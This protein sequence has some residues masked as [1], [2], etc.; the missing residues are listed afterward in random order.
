MKQMERNDNW[1]QNKKNWADTALRARE[2]Y[3]IATK[4]GKPVIVM[5]PIKGGT[6]ANVPEEAE[7]ILKAQ[8]PE[9]SVA[10]WAVRFA[11]THEN[12]MMVLSG[13]SNM[14][15]MEDNISYMKDF[16]SLNPYDQS[17]IHSNVK[18]SDY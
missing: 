14:E 4:H 13:M 12:V 17:F 9:L 7:R 16:T 15:Q 6:L 1:L 8:T 5:E 2:C 10:S 11:A 3:E 18:I